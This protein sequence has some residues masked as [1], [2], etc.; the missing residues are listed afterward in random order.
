[1]SARLLFAGVSLA[2]LFCFPALS[3]QRLSSEQQAWVSKA[4]RADR[5]GWIY[6]HTEGEPRQRGFQHGYLLAKEIA[7]G[8]RVARAEWEHNSGMDWAWL[9][10]RTAAMFA[11][12]VD[13][14]NMA[15]LEGISEGA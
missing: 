7:E 6:L 5:A 15:E 10:K 2:C 14:E 12:K 4:R 9:S 11:P 3:Q 1:M 8:L 13:P